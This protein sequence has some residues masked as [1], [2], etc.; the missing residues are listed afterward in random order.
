M[1][2]TN[3]LLKRQTLE[4]FSRIAGTLRDSLLAS[5][6]Q[7]AENGPPEVLPFLLATAAA[8][9]LHA[10]AADVLAD[11]AEQHSGRL[12]PDHDQGAVAIALHRATQWIALIRLR[13]TTDL[14]REGVRP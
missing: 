13:N 14:R 12:C 9:G 8:A 10:D 7:H 2:T 3:I 11:V 4:N 5:L 6:R 1:T